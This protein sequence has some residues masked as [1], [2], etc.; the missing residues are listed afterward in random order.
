VGSGGGG[1]TTGFE[2]VPAILFWG[3]PDGEGNRAPAAKTGGSLMEITGGGQINSLDGFKIVSEGCVIEM[4]GGCI[5]LGGEHI[6][7]NASNIT[8]SGGKV[9]VNGDEVVVKGGPIRL[10]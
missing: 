4:S 9:K 5:T 7:L 1:A 3:P 2:D 8:L 10:N 6:C